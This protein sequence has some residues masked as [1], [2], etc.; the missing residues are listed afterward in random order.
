MSPNSKTSMSWLLNRFKIF[1]P[2]NDPP[3]SLEVVIGLGIIDLKTV[4]LHPGVQ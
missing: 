1:L 4:L 3:P 2:D